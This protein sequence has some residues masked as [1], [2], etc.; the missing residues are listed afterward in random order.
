MIIANEDSEAGKVYNSCA[1]KFIENI[2]NLISEP[3]K[4]DVFEKI[5]EN[6]KSLSNIIS[7]NIEETSFNEIKN[8][9]EEKKMKLNNKDVL[10]LK[11]CYFDELG[12]YIFKSSNVDI[13]YN[14]F[15]P[16]SDT[17][18]IR[19]ESPGNSKLKLIIKLGKIT[20]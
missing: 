8:I 1:F 9:L 6:F 12:F 14:I 11:N 19:I 4:F 20:H 13:K 18:E 2:Y 17:I 3:Q 15:K 7:N 16:D 5:K 10:T